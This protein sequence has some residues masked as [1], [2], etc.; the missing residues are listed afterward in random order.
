MEELCLDLL[1]GLPAVPKGAIGFIS[2]KI[3]KAAKWFML[4]DGKS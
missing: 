3:Y 4:K 2:K 1:Y